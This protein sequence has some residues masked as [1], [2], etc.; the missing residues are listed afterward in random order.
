MNQKESRMTVF[1]FRETLGANF[2]LSPAQ[3]PLQHKDAYLMRCLW[4]ATLHEHSSWQRPF[5]R[6]PLMFSI[7]DVSFFHQ[8]ASGSQLW[9]GAVARRGW[10][11]FEFVPCHRNGVLNKWKK[12]VSKVNSRA[13]RVFTLNGGFVAE[14]QSL[15][16]AWMQSWSYEREE[17]DAKEKFHRHRLWNMNMQV[18]TKMHPK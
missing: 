12:S 11:S 14:I 16:V 15:S 10:E 9:V 3:P 6:P 7:A 4:Q 5:S 13:Q 17:K 1:H 18:W 8:A 2:R